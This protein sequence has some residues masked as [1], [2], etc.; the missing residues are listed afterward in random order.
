MLA[1]V[2][3]ICEKRWDA[4]KGDCSGF[5]KAVASDFGIKLTGQ[6]NVI[7]DTMGKPP[8]T[9]L[10]SDTAKAAQY[11]KLGYL[12]VAGLKAIPHGHVAVIVP[13]TP[14]PYLTGY[15]GML[16]GIG[17]KNTTLNWSWNKIDL[18]KVQYF[19]IRRA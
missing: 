10:G 16:G 8:W 9:Q 17:R 4:N 15:W 11:A 12:V 5:L 3:A 19:A 6:A 13:V 14:N 1:T 7:I 18:P 2:K